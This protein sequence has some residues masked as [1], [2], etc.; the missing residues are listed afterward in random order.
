MGSMSRRSGESTGE[1]SARADAEYRAAAEALDVES[2]RLGLD[3][4]W[5][6]PPGRPG[7]VLDAA[8]LAALERLELADDERAAAAQARDGGR[9]DHSGVQRGEFT[10]QG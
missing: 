1:W 7:P 5:F 10:R 9:H 8:Y 4:W 2:R 6:P 3:R